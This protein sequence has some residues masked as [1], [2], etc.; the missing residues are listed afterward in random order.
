MRRG[1]WRLWFVI[2]CLWVVFWAWKLDAA[3]YAGFTFENWYCDSPFADPVGAYA[4]FF[5]TLFGVPV[6]VAVLALA[7]QWVIAGFRSSPKQQ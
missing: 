1:L 6:G 7:V 2:S 3:C 4:K 5:G